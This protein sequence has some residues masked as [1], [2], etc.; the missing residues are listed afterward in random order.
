LIQGKCRDGRI[1]YS[2]NDIG[3]KGKFYEEEEGTTELYIFEG[4]CMAEKYL[5]EN[6]Q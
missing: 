4:L 1:H 5:L 2:E 3:I 6:R